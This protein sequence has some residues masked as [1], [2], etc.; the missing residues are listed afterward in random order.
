MCPSLPLYS[1]SSEVPA[2]RFIHLYGPDNILE[3]GLISQTRLLSM[4]WQLHIEVV[5]KIHSQG[6]TRSITRVGGTRQISWAQIFVPLT[7]LRMED[8]RPGG[9]VVAASL[10][11][12]DYVLCDS[13]HRSLPHACP[14]VRF[15]RFLGAIWKLCQRESWLAVSPGPVEAREFGHI[16]TS[17]TKGYTPK[18]LVRSLRTAKPKNSILSQHNPITSACPHMSCVRF[19]RFLGTIRQLFAPELVRRTAPRRPHPSAPRLPSGALPH[20]R[21]K[22]WQAPSGRALLHLD[23]DFHGCAL[24]ELSFSVLSLTLTELSFGSN[25][26]SLG[27][28]TLW[29]R[30]PNVVNFSRFHRPRGYRQSGFSL[31]KFPNGSWEPQKSHSRRVGACGSGGVMLWQNWVFN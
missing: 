19:L 12:C 1:A 31:T 7:H 8:P 17:A 27:G 2:L 4:I 20:R 25:L 13:L 26:F 28:V 24:T 18:T 22:C 10:A 3:L 23:V 11:L 16:W 5:P 9:Q 15:L 30:S 6:R 14:W 29:R 21:A